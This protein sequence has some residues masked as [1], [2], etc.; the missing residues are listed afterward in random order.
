MAPRLPSK[1]LVSALMRRVEQAGGFATVLARGEEWGGVILIQAFEKGQFTGLF[2][3]MFDLDGVPRLTPC[4]PPP[5]SPPDA[6][7]SYLDRR[8]A[9]DS[10]LWIIELDIAEAERFA[11]E[12]MCNG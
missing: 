7:A 3:R 11:A 5:S 12:T 10:D 6:L 9:T 4:G 8:R 1:L 2:E